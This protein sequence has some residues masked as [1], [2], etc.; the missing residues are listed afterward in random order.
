MDIFITPK[1]KAISKC[2]ASQLLSGFWGNSAE[3][4]SSGFSE[5][6]K[7]AR[8]RNGVPHEPFA[9]PA[10]KLSHFLFK[11][12][13]EVRWSVAGGGPQDGATG[14]EPRLQSRKE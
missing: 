6:T 9:L 5:I 4:N 11:E 10:T 8:G 1:Q 2:G 14:R 3:V 12:V 13:E 7:E